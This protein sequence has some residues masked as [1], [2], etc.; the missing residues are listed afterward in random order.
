MSYPNNLKNGFG[1]DNCYDTFCD[2]ELCAGI[3]CI[4]CIG[5]LE[6]RIKD[7]VIVSPIPKAWNPFDECLAKKAYRDIYLGKALP[8]R[9]QPTCFQKTCFPLTT[10]VKNLGE[11]PFPE[12]HNETSVLDCGSK[13]V[14]GYLHK[15]I[16]ETHDGGCVYT[17]FCWKPLLE[18]GPALAFVRGVPKVVWPYPWYDS[19]LKPIY[20][21]VLCVPFLTGTPYV[22]FSALKYYA[23]LTIY[24]NNIHFVIVICFGERTADCCSKAMV[25]MR[26]HE[27]CCNSCHQIP[28]NFKVPE[29][30]KGQY[31][32]YGNMNTLGK[33][34]AAFRKHALYVN[35]PYVG[36][37]YLPKTVF[38][39][40]SMDD[41]FSTSN[42]NEEKIHYNQVVPESITME[43]GD[44]VK[45]RAKKAW[46]L[47]DFDYSNV[48]V[49][50]EIDKKQNFELLSTM[51]E[52]NKINNVNAKDANGCTLVYYL[53]KWDD[54]LHLVKLLHAK[55]ASLTKPNKFGIT[56]LMALVQPLGL[57]V[58]KRKDP[59]RIVALKYLLKH[60][61]LKDI[62]ARFQDETALCMA[63]EASD[64]EEIALIEEHG[65]IQ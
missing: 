37:C 24:T 17:N 46:E 29:G 44:T 60:L 65:G 53:C 15:D 59:N 12:L 50:K 23:A 11:N 16:R 22:V 3:R 14:S 28:P 5:S 42:L 48:N 47:E 20:K 57:R 45:E 63:I 31:N 38:M 43:R 7:C 25:E 54:P 56:P 30:W 62:N 10:V 9:K 49:F 26:M 27:W 8:V 52:K 34:N 32:V 1:N 40:N 13:Y 58:D 4:L 33:K 39:P 51:I 18:P 2:A 6:T 64:K 55:G 35:Y 21:Y 61:S 36:R 41:N 19:L